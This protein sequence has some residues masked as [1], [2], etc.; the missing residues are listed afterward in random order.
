MAG[1]IV[2]CCGFVVFIDSLT[3]DYQL[4]II[5]VFL[6]ISSFRKAPHGLFNFLWEAT[7]KK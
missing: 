2:L 1:I 4:M 5:T 7:L 3:V 6:I